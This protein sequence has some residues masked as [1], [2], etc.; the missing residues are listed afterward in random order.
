MAKNR[1]YY[2]DENT[3]SFVELKPKRSRIIKRSALVLLVSLFL[4]GFISWGMDKVI[5]TPQELALIEENAVLQEQLTHVRERMRDFSA[6]LSM[7]SQSDQNLYRT[8]L[9]ADP[10]PED[11]LMMGVGGKDKYEEF[12]RFSPNTSDQLKAT[13]E[14]L[15]ELERKVSLQNQ[16]YR[17]LASL[18]EKR[19]DWLVQ[20]PA[21]LPANGRVTSGFGMRYHPILKIRRMHAGI[22]ILLPTGSPVYATGDGV[23]LETGRNS[24]LGTYLKVQ[25]PA[26]GYTTVYGH[27]SEIPKDI[28]RGKKVK[29]GDQ[30]GLSGNSGLSTAPHLHYEVRDSKTR[31][32]YNPIF[33]FLPSMTPEQYQE[34]FTELEANTSSLD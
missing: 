34:M 19:S 20:M 32:P 30:I 13:A 33:L 26:T 3:F 7:L 11:V 8:I 22:D 18:A 16:S 10:I 1:Y 31:K 12:D 2:Y 15:D 29:R 6:E 25:H 24:G 27:L 17:E 4:A 28:K 23:I 14:L 5:G 21:I 9:Q